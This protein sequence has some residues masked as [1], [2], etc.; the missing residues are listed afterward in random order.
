[1]DTMVATPLGQILSPSLTSPNLTP[2]LLP[3]PRRPMAAGRKSLLEE[4]SVLA[5]PLPGPVLI[6]PRPTRGC[7]NTSCT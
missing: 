7:L 2:N 4:L 6:S 3:I 1:M 5:A